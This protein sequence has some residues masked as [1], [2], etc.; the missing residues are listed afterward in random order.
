MKTL[1]IKFIDRITLIFLYSIFFMITCLILSVLSYIPL[2]EY[3]YYDLSVVYVTGIIFFVLLVIRF[4]IPSFEKLIKFEYRIITILT[5]TITVIIIILA[6]LILTIILLF[7]GIFF[8]LST[9]GYVFIAITPII[10]ILLCNLINTKYLLILNTTIICIYTSLMII[11]LI[12]QIIDYNLLYMLQN[13]SFM[14][15]P[16]IILCIFSYVNCKLV[17]D[18]EKT[19][20]IVSLQR[21]IGMVGFFLVVLVMFF[22]GAIITTMMVPIGPI[23]I[24]FIFFIFVVVPYYVYY[25][26]I[27]ILYGKYKKEQEKIAVKQL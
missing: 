6:I 2:F 11:Y 19:Y 8:N 26:V 14:V 9:I 7:S 1:N 24:T 4:I 22:A 16:L 25:L 20:D 3:F 15:I 27:Q 17:F 5:S 13:F 18:K 23:M 10:S 21:L 12:Q